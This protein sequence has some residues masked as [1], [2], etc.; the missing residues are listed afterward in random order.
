MSGGAQLGEV[1]VLL[2]LPIRRHWQRYQAG[3]GIR[4]RFDEASV[5][6]CFRA[7]V[8]SLL[9]VDELEEVPHFAHRRMV[10]EYLAGLELP[11]HDLRLAREWLRAE[12]GLDLAPVVDAELERFGVP[13]I[14]T[15][16]SRRGPWMHAV[17]AQRGDVVFDPSGI[18]YG[19]P[20]TLRDRDADESA[21]LV[22]AEPYDPDPLE[23]VRAWYLCEPTDG[24]IVGGIA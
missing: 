21:G 14:A 4:G 22:L 20:Y 8:A 17:I 11:W 5:G 16:H 15:V 3:H 1:R 9:G 2:E 23:L 24:G 19:T 13:Y 10:D 12:H 7:C 18:S 6:D